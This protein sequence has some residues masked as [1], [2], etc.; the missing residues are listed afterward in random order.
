MR[1]RTSVGFFSAWGEVAREKEIWKLGVVYFMF[2]FSY[3]IYVTFFVAYLTSEAGLPPKKAGQ[4]FA[5]LGLASIMSGALWGSLSDVLGRRHGSLLAYLTV[6]LS[7]LLIALWRS[8]TG[9]YVSSIVFGLSMSS[10]P[11]IKA[12]AVGDSVG[13]RLAPA[14]LG[15]ITLI[16]G[17]GQSLGPAVAGWIKDATGTFAWAFILCTIVSL[18][19]AAGSLLLRKKT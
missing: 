3:I 9:A 17:I 4:I 10:L 7:F 8:T 2:G 16:F 18:T 19:G 5:L 1:G 12:A 11:A 13:G 15:L 6:A 14:A